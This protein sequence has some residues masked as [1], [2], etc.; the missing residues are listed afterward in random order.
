M[1][2]PAPSGFNLGA[3]LTRLTRQSDIM[4]AVAMAVI[5]GVMIVPLPEF[6]LDML[7]IVNVSAALMMLL[8]SMYTT[9]PL[10]FSSFPSLLLVLT[11]FRLALNVAASRLILLQGHAGEVIKAFGDFVV[12]GS[13]VVGIVIFLIL[14]VIQFV[15]ITN[16]AGR[17][18][19]VAAR[20]T[21][22][23]MP[24]KQ[25]AI[26]ADLSAGAIDEVTA[27]A[28][29]KEITQ[30]ADFYGSMDGASKFVKGDAIAG[31]VIIIVNILGGLTIGV[32]QLGMPIMTALQ[33]YTLMTLGDGLVSQIP[34]LLI[35][36]ATGI[37]VT[38]SATDSN[39]GHDIG[40]QV[41]GN[42]RAL[43]MVA[44]VLAMLAVIPGLPKVPLFVMAGTLAGLAYALQ[45]RS[46]TRAQALDEAEHAEA[47]QQASAAASTD[48][49]N[50]RQ[51]LKVDPMEIE[52][53]YMLIPL[54]DPEQDGTLLGRV[55]VIRRQMA[56]ELGIILPT[57]RVRDNAQID[58]NTYVIKLRGV[59][60]A[61]GEVRP[62][63]MMAMNPGLAEQEIDGIPAVEPA[64][65]LPA[66][67]ITPDEQERA[68]M[69]GYT[70]VDPASV[71]TTHLSEVI[72]SSA[73]SIISRQD[74]QSLLDHVKE[75]NP[76]LISEVVPDL[77]AIGDVQRVLQNL[78]RERVSVRDLV[79][80][81][82]AVAD[83][84]RLTKDPDILAE[85]ARSSLGR[86]ITSQYAADDGRLHVMTL[87][88]ALQ[89]E[90]A[91]TMVATERG[92]SFQLEP[93]QGQQLMRSVR[94]SMERMAS[95]GYQPVLL[96]PARIRLAVRRFTEL[97]LSSLVVMAYSE[98][99]PNVQV[100]A[101]E[102]VSLPGVEA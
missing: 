3:T 48:A 20:F 43:Y 79:T 71:I 10:Q 97:S 102:M 95:S 80:V 81:L 32:L 62:N 45:R 63:R 8:V 59:Q 40:S 28:R 47:M 101:M 14:I 58:P 76:A 100:V 85:Q 51:F 52:I 38:R 50:V 17:V 92:P 93:G 33:N 19:E 6:I 94:E 53:G 73:A 67:W 7:I 13:Y 86:Q 30:E 91:R 87:A 22:D 1:E 84:A 21:L 31:I 54:T 96:C 60:V 29:R 57:I 89:H 41:F 55:T 82:E 5:L 74:V 69:L 72:R 56:L 77:L 70:V 23:S 24:G 64:F 44:G 49:E 61:T 99:S 11:L 18:A 4:L 68:E 66:I 39:L 98:V 46:A 26:D 2:A 37:I 27:R 75:E 34:A 12:G 78:L 42:P 36:T 15:V 65:G 9:H 25:M 35:S 83:Q 16:G 88:P 90:L